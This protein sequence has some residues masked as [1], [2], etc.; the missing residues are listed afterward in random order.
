M[1]VEEITD[2]GLRQR[3]G[4][5]AS[6]DEKK[7]VEVMSTSSSKEKDTVVGAGD[8]EKLEEL[9]VDVG[10]VLEETESYSLESNHSPYAEG[11]SIGSLV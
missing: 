11:R 7:G 3:T 9:E 1:P 4:E 8:E 10:A 5:R 6:L 2:D